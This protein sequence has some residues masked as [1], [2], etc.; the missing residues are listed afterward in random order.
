MKVSETPL[1][2]VSLALGKKT[3]KTIQFIVTFFF[4][5]LYPYTLKKGT[6]NC[7]L[8]VLENGTM[9]W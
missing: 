7:L 8:Y 2:I 5:K 3:L 4:F 6:K 9:N 1:K